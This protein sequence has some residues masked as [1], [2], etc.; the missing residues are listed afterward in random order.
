MLSDVLTVLF[1]VVLWATV[2]SAIAYMASEL[3]F[4]GKR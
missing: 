3:D 1:Q 4:G 2:I